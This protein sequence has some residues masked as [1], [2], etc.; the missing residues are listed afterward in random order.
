LATLTPF[1]H[2][3]RV[4]FSETDLTGCLHFAHLLRFFEEAEQGL[5]RELQIPMIWH[6][7]DGL[8]RGWPRVSAECDLLQ[9]IPLAAELEILVRVERVRH[10]SVQL[11]FEVMHTT[12]LVARGALR[13]ACIAAKPGQPMRA[14]AIPDDI[15]QKLQAL[16]T[17]PKSS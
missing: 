17:P 4:A 11:T 7:S 16:A 6:G 3:R 13:L 10:S 1:R 5:F 15:A 2:L 14:A 12:Q 9:P 8:S